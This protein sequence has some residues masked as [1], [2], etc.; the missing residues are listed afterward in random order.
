MLTRRILFPLLALILAS[1]ACALPGGTTASPQPIPATDT[2]IPTEAAPTSTPLPVATDTP[3]PAGLTLDQL[4]NAEVMMTTV[5]EPKLVKLTDGKYEQNSDPT[6]YA[7]VSM[8]QQV[9][10]GD[11]NGDGASDAAIII[12]ENFGGSGVFVSVVAMLNQGGQPVYGGSLIIDDRPAVNSIAI[13]DGEILLDGIVHGP[14]DP[15]CCPAQPVTRSYRLWSGKLILTHVT[16]KTPNGDERILKIDSPAAGSE[17][18]GP[19]TVNGSV[20]IAPFENT[21][22]YA[23]FLEG[24]PD[25]I[26]QSSLM[27][28][29]AEMGGPGTFALPLDFSSAG[30]QGHIRIEISDLSAADGSELALATLFVT[31]K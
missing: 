31:I 8:G 30:I 26:V 25:P 23:V 12:G 17:I 13:Q 5:G 1:A 3:I 20:T 4:K 15:G 10:Y 11:L 22:S 16:T 24:T 28:T 27:V 2:L 18:S 7:S 19:F 21:L 29:A 6:N 9:A 14:N